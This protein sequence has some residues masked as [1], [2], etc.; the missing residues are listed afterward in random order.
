MF[1]GIDIIGNNAGEILVVPKKQVENGKYGMDNK[2]R[3]SF[4]EV[5]FEL[6][7]H[8]LIR[9]INYSEIGFNNK[10]YYSHPQNNSLINQS[11]FHVGN[12]GYL[13]GVS[14]ADKI[15]VIS[16]NDKILNGSTI[17]IYKK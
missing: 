9:R 16:A 7:E 8:S 15:T 3:Y 2:Y 5:V 17:E 12:K 11:M 6:E 13:D 1:L 4:E 14:L 10:L